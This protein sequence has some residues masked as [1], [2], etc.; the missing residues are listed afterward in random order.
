MKAR[1]RI[2]WR[3]SFQTFYSRQAFPGFYDKAMLHKILKRSQANTEREW[4]A[5][6]R[7]FCTEKAISSIN[8]L[9]FIRHYGFYVLKLMVVWLVSLHLTLLCKREN[10]ICFFCTENFS[11]VDSMS[12]SFSHLFILSVTSKTHLDMPQMH[13][14]TS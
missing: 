14:H 4:K 13:F 11:M 6:K 10:S 12:E 5:I 9:Q 1:I 8:S 3:L 7:E 2:A